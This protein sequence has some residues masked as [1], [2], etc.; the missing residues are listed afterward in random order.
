MNGERKLFNGEEQAASAI[1][2]TASATLNNIFLAILGVLYRTVFVHYF[3]VNYLGING[4]FSN[5]IDLLSLSELGITTPIIYRLYKP[6]EENDNERVAQLMSF[7]KRVYQFIFAFITFVG[8]CIC[9]FIK[10]LINDSADIPNDINIYVVY[11]L[12][13][14]QTSSTYL[15]SYKQALLIADRRQYIV[16]IFQIVFNALKNTLQIILVILFKKY[17]LILFCGILATVFTNYLFAVY[18]TKQYPAVFKKRIVLDEKTKK[19]IFSE[20]KVCLVHKVGYKILT[21]T[22]NIIISKYVGIVATGLYSNYLLI[23]NMAFAFVSQLTGNLVAIVGKVIAQ[24][25]MDY[26]GKIFKRLNFL[27]LWINCTVSCCMGIFLDKLIELWLGSG[28]NLTKYTAG[29]ITFYFFISNLRHIPNTY[30]G[31]SSLFARDALRTVFQVLINI[32]IS[33]LLVKKILIDG[34]IIGS[35]LCVLTTVFWREPYLVYK[36][37]LH[38]K[39]NEYWKQLVMFFIPSVIIVS[40][41]KAIFRYIAIDSFAKL[42]ICGIIVF[43][44]IQGV[45]VIMFNKTVEYKYFYTFFVTKVKLLKK[46]HDIKLEK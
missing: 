19:S 3:S 31:V 8:L 27:S 1:K 45:F 43:L 23:Y 42:I 5:I 9:P 44:V 40:A 36:E 24:G 41:F 22:D 32:V 29:L 37:L 20:T 46:K 12:F 33:I 11:I 17:E 21:A 39:W 25:D 14:A 7:Y 38:K 34:V 35:I 28:L 16:N 10:M 4:L 6:I 15:F 26:A 30:I 18:I 2:V 13:L